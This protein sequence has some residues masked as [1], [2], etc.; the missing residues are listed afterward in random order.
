[1]QR[2]RRLDGRARRRGR[3]RGRTARPGAELVERVERGLRYLTETALRE[4]GYFSSSRVADVLAAPHTITAVL[5][6][7]KARELGLVTDASA[8][9][10]AIDW[11]LASQDDARRLV[12][13]EVELDPTNRYP[14]L[15]VTDS[16]LIRVLSQSTRKQDRD[17]TLFKAALHSVKDRIE[18]ERGACYGYRVFTWSTARAVSAMSAASTAVTDFPDRPAEY[19]GQKAG[20]VLTGVMILMLGLAAVLGFTGRFSTEVAGF[21]ALVVLAVL[22]VNRRIGE[23]TFAQLLGSVARP[24]KAAQG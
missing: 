19:H 2:A 18:P 6:L 22:L 23:K 3:D 4:P 11:L 20:P 1:M 5:A 9:E 10:K 16:L 24:D 15:Y 12:V 7:Q 17:S 13:E 21:F 14:F 8:E